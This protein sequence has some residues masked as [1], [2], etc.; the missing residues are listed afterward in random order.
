VFDEFT[1]QDC[2]SPSLW[3]Y[4]LSNKI[5]T[6]FEKISIEK[7]NTAESR[8]FN[9]CAL[10]EVRKELLPYG[11]G[12]CIITEAWSLTVAKN[13]NYHQATIT[14]SKYSMWQVIKYP[15]NLRDAP[16]KSGLLQ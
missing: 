12:Q 13:Q 1:S 11:I 6:L 5:F 16:L 7:K 9:D 3:R 2:G 4:F 10:S 8:G 14:G 15:I